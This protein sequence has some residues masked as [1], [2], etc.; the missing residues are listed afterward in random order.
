[1][2]CKSN[3]PLHPE[4]NKYNS[5]KTDILTIRLSFII[6]SAFIPLNN[7]LKLTQNILY[8]TPLYQLVYM[9]NDINYLSQY[10]SHSAIIIQMHK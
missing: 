1:M 9:K 6:I 8:K 4:I 2:T 5:G 7:I 3:F 10:Q